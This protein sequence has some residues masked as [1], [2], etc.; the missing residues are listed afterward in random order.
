MSKAPRRPDALLDQAAT[1][2][3]DGQSEISTGYRDRFMLAVACAYLGTEMEGDCEVVDDEAGDADHLRDF[4]P[5][6]SG[7][8]G[9]WVEGAPRRWVMAVERMGVSYAVSVIATSAVDAR[10]H[11]EA[12]VDADGVDQWPLIAW[13]A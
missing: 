10:R 12:V 8:D 4:G 13:P 6:M 2:I 7:P 11:A 5:T 9:T 1:A 3:R